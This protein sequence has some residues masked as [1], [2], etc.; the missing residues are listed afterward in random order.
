MK[1][2]SDSRVFIEPAIHKEFF[3]DSVRLYETPDTYL[4]DLVFV[5]VGH[6]PVVEGDIPQQLTLAKTETSSSQDLGTT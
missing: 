4:D 2:T 1:I 6:E 3:V 5:T